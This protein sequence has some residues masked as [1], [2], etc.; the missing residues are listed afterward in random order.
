MTW[1]K[2]LQTIIQTP[3]WYCSVHFWLIVAIAAPHIHTNATAEQPTAQD[4]A[5]DRNIVPFITWIKARIS[6]HFANEA[7]DGME[8]KEEKKLRHNRKEIN[9]F[10]SDSFHYAAICPDFQ[11]CE[12]L[13]AYLSPFESFWTVPPVSDAFT[14]HP[15]HLQMQCTYIMSSRVLRGVSEFVNMNNNHNFTF[16]LT[17]KFYVVCKKHCT[18]MRAN[19]TIEHRFDWSVENKFSIEYKIIWLKI[20]VFY[21]NCTFNLM[22]SS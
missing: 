12:I 8:K 13:L 19:Q 3:N 4:S 15:R 1:A 11:N 16:F 6:P 17:A 5:A 2:P 10:P 9:F 20:K 18:R 14:L 7:N 21:C 22:N